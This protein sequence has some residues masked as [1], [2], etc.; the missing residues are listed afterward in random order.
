M[1][2]WIRSI[3]H[4]III[5]KSPRV[6]RLIGSGLLLSKIHS[7]HPRLEGI[8]ILLRR[9]LISKNDRYVNI[10]GL[11]RTWLVRCTNISV[12]VTHDLWKTSINEY[13]I[14]YGF[15]C[16]ECFL[17]PLQCNLI[18]IE[19]VLLL[20]SVAMRL[21]M[22]LICHEAIQDHSLFKKIRSGIFN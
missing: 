11:Y 3:A 20:L 1:H 5:I 15:E 9:I 17:F 10:T 6:V 8:L 14:D 19:R 13:T 7:P 4:K 12:Y 2:K 21:K 22:I 16:N 18:G